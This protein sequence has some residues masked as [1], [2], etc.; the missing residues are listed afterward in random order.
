MAFD[1]GLMRIGVAI[2]NNNLK[3]AHPLEIVTGKNNLEKMAQIT[4]LIDTWKPFELIVGMPNPTDDKIDLI[5]NIKKFINRLK[6]NFKLNVV[7]INEDYTSLEA[8]KLLNQQQIYG[9]KQ[10]NKL[11]SLSAVV[12]LNTYFSKQ[13][14][15]EHDL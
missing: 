7:I 4:K 10:K 11:D 2:A 9:I 14:I 6:Y 12:I 15:K 1:F 13:V 8:S 5:N 3:I